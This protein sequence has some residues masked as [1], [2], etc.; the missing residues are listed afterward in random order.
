MM[1][2]GTLHLQQ[3]NTNRHQVQGFA[4]VQMP[5]LMQSIVASELAPQPGVWVLQCI[6]GVGK[7]REWSGARGA[8]EPA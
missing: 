3:R 7:H 4:C 2:V 6:R 5:Q 1:A 8:V